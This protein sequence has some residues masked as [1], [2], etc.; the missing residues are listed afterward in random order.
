MDRL[1]KKVSQLMASSSSFEIFTLAHEL[2]CMT[3]GS[4]KYR[5]CSTHDRSQTQASVRE[6]AD[7][8]GLAWRTPL[9]LSLFL[10]DP[11]VQWIGPATSN[12]TMAVRICPGVPMVLK[13][14][15]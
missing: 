3:S 7:S 9:V 10:Y 11:V 4:Q 2:G 14:N 8:F 13:A 15:G 1:I 5:Y 12:R 6:W